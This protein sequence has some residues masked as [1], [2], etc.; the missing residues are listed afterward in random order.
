MNY[1][2]TSDAGSYLAADC[3]PL[4]RGASTPQPCDGLLS[5]LYLEGA[6]SARESGGHYA[7]NNCCSKNQS[8]CGSPRGFSAPSGHGSHRVLCG[9]RQTGGALLQKRVRL[10]KPRLLR[11]G[12][13]NKGSSKLRDSSEQTD[14]CPNDAAAAG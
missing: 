4:R 10:S 2:V 12:N 8:G 9:Q 1:V 13:G 14:L 11:A 6:F 5:I 7:N 3:L